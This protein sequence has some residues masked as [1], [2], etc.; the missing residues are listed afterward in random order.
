MAR[1]LAVACVFLLLAACASRPCCPP[2][3]VVP[4]RD[5]AG[6]LSAVFAHIFPDPDRRHLA[7]DDQLTPDEGVFMMP[8]GIEDYDPE[9][10]LFAD[11]LDYLPALNLDTAA[12]FVHR[13]HGTEPLPTGI[14]WPPGIDLGGDA[15]FQS[16]DAWYRKHPE[17]RGILT[18]APVGF[19]RD[20][21]QALVFY[22]IVREGLDGSGNVVLLER[23]D[24][25][26]R[27]IA[28]EQVWIS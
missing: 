17:S 4:R 20:G 10:A 3:E 11:M 25:G 1:S 28:E 9:K 22:S 12:D 26:W 14:H 21:R 15:A 8:Y 6:V 2:R 23:T 5:V 18:F 19:S 24:G 16:W 27:V 7:V 13:Q